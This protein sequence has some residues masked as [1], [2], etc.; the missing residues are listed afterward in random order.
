MQILCTS[1]RLSR[2]IAFLAPNTFS[3][4]KVN[5]NYNTPNKNNQSS[6]SYFSSTSLSSC[7]FNNFNSA[8]IPQNNV[9]VSCKKFHTS[10]HLRNDLTSIYNQRK[11][12]LKGKKKRKIVILFPCKFMFSFVMHSSHP[13]FSYIYLKKEET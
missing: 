2:S 6:C 7:N 11:E 3:L 1:C 10:G 12:Q 5:Y 4:F 13:R 8:S 9:D